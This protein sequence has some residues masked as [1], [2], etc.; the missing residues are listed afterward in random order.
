MDCS[1]P[2]SSVHGILQARILE[3]VAISF[4]RGSFPPRDQTHR[5]RQLLYHWAIREALSRSSLVFLKFRSANVCGQIIICCGGCPGHLYDVEQRSWPLPLDVPSAVTTRDF[6]RHCDISPGD[7]NH[8]WLRTSG[9]ER[10]K[11]KQMAWWIRSQE[12]RQGV[13]PCNWRQES[14]G[15]YRL[16]SSW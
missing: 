16:R 8:P 4:F 7:Q 2:G 5:S 13:S 10:E 6:S 9:V 12:R 3:W 1:P 15:R 14:Q 11:D